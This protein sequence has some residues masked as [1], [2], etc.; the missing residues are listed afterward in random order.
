MSEGIFILLVFVAFALILI[1]RIP[2]SPKGIQGFESKGPSNGEEAQ[3]ASGV[4]VMEDP[5]N[6]PY[7]T[8]GINSVDD[9]EYNLVFRN[10]GDR[11]MT[12]ETRDFLMSS[13]PKDWS[14][15]PPSSELF[16]EGLA[17]FKESF[18]GCSNISKSNPYKEVDGS[19]MT[20]PDYNKLDAQEKEVLST[21]VPKK[22]GELTTYDAEDAKEIIDRIYK[23]K[24]LIPDVKQIDENVFTIMGTRPASSGAGASASSEGAEGEESLPDH[25]VASQDAVVSSGEI[26]V[27]MTEPKVRDRF[28]T[29]PQER[30][31]D[32]KW[33]YTSW[34]PGLE[35]MFAP[36]DP[37]KN[38][39]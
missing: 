26:P 29:N 8:Q 20:P 16:Q 9:Y 36:T 21:Y 14:T 38:W 32:G 37:Q 2:K 25:A 11:A 12:K 17:A 23:A 13:Y 33:D 31:R 22:P 19:N 18:T 10:E 30:T 6:P 35:R 24:G 5:V 15:N 34:T 4:I 3:D 1:T 39:Y 28:F 7:A 27:T